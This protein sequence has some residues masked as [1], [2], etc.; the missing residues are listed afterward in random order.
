MATAEFTISAAPKDNTVSRLS[1]T[2]AKTSIKL[3]WTRIPSAAGYEIYG[4]KCDKGAYKLLKTVTKNTTTSWS[5]TK[6][7]K[8]TG[9]SYYVKPTQ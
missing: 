1:A 5:N 6:L 7:K 2:A 4:R 9:Y 8:A 3:K